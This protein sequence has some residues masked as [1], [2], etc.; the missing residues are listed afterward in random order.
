ME[1]I[2]KLFLGAILVGTILL[3]IGLWAPYVKAYFRRTRRERYMRNL[4]IILL[5][6]VAIPAGSQTIGQLVVS[7]AFMYAG[8]YADGVAETLEFNY[9]S[10]HDRH[11]KTDPQWSNPDI[12]WRN[13]WRN[14]SP[15]QGPAF[16]G[17]TTI[18]VGTT[19]LY[20]AMHSV[21]NLATTTSL[22][23]Y[24]IPQFRKQEGNWWQKRWTNWMRT[25]RLEKEDHDRK[26][27]L[28]YVFEAGF[29]TGCRSVGRATS[30]N[31]IYN[32]N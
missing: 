17:S 13:K 16:P 32:G 4:P 14:G 1:T 31:W 2:G 18:F 27:V 5:I 30:Y 28:A 22:V 24:G 23:I 6:A 21:R 11:P 15:S 20:H 8:G 3:I 19:D 10:Y 26:P 7:G 9:K 12:S 25:S 29:L